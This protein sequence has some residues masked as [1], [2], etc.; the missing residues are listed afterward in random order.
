MRLADA[1]T[2]RRLGLT[3]LIDVVFILLLFFMVATS[4]SRHA[5]LEL[6][7]GRDGATEAPSEI[8]L[9]I[10]VGGDGDRALNGVPMTQDA[11]IAAIQ[12][13]ATDGAAS[14]IV[15]PVGQATTGDVIGVV[16]ALGAAGIAD[17][18]LLRRER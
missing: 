5:A 1:P 17:V 4:F 10:S 18:T 13:R 7:S 11:L 16:D 12:D 14:V 15:A 8:R 6:G 9:L 3:P 2:R